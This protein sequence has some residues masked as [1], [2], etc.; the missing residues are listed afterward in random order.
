M[1]VP[2]RPGTMHAVGHVVDTQP[3][4]G[5]WET[6]TGEGGFVVWRGVD[7]G[8]MGGERDRVVRRWIVM[9]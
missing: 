9:W 5:K 6:L 8:M 3:L 1:V 7:L 4:R 2:I